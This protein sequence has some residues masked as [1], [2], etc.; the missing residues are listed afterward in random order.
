MRSESR[1]GQA[2]IDG[3]S[4]ETTIDETRRRIE[5]GRTV[6]ITFILLDGVVETPS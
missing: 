3:R 2:W 5:M 6:A 4:H 1:N